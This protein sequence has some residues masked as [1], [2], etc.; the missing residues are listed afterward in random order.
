MQV[1]RVHALGRR[2]L[3][4]SGEG[5]PALAPA[6]AFRKLVE[7]FERELK[8]GLGLTLDNTIR[9]RLWARTAADR[10]A[11]SDERRRLLTGKAR[12]ASSSYIA[13]DHF[14]SAAS[15]GLDLVAMEPNS[16]ANAKVVVEYD[17]PIAPPL[18]VV[19]E[20]IVVL[21]GL[22]LVEPTLE[23]AVPKTIAKLGEFMA[24]AG[25]GWPQVARIASFVK[26]PNGLD[27]MERVLEA[28]LPNG[29]GRA[30]YTPIDGLA[31]DGAHVEIEV[32]ARLQ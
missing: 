4:L 2:M 19:Y 7:Q 6:A 25:V 18:Y 11:A 16:P 26:R 31:E 20:G 32:T 23:V 22:C 24:K 17:P 13:A 1:K 29:G 9:T 30:E 5:D 27:T 21:S 15:V 10:Q 28:A 8:S 12:A 14:Y 3:Y